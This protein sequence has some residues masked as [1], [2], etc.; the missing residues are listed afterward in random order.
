MSRFWLRLGRSRVGELSIGAP[1]DVSRSSLALVLPLRTST[2]SYATTSGAQEN[3]F[4]FKL[5]PEFVHAYKSIQP[6]FGSHPANCLASLQALS[7]NSSRR[8][9]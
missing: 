6:P 3:G 1:L 9:F 4:A 7:L 5:S 2:R 8:S